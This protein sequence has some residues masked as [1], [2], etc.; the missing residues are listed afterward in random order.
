MQRCSHVVAHLGK[1]GINTDGSIGTR[2]VPAEATS[3]ALIIASAAAAREE[4]PLA[5]L[6]ARSRRGENLLQPIIIR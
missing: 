2:R 6:D 5:A 3:V 1:P 4:H